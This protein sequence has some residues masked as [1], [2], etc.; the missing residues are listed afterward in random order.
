M[1]PLFQQIRQQLPQAAILLSTTTETGQEEAKRSMPDADAHFFLPLDFSW[2]IRR[3]FCKIQ[4]TTLILSESDFWYHLLQE[5]KK[6]KTQVFLV[7][8]KLSERS[9]RRFKQFP[10]FTKRL[11]APFTALY[12]QSERYKERFLS[13]GIPEEKLHTTGNLKLDIPLKKMSAIEEDLFRKTLH[14]QPTDPLL[15]IGSTHAPEETLFLSLLQKLWKEIPSLKVLLVPRHPERFDSVASLLEERGVNFSRFSNPQPSRLI[16]IDQMGLLN[17]CYQIA[18]LALVGGS[19]TPHIGGHN[20]FEPLF[21]GVPVLFGPYM[22]NQTDLTDLILS[23]Q[24]GQQIPLETLFSTIHTLL[25]TPSLYKTYVSACHTLA[26]GVQG[27]TKRT[28]DQLFSMHSK[29]FREN[30]EL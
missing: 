12:L 18:T 11:F 15:V 25:T 22:H 4:P 6:R 1:I 23:A 5:A 19:Y 2:V 3:L 8:G 29:T 20:I 24:A 9:S 30:V 26:Q 17:S 16:L 10:F 27:S 21:H 7:N 14:I 28:F 13:L